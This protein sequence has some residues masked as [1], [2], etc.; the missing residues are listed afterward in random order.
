[1]RPLLGVQLQRSQTLWPSLMMLCIRLSIDPVI[2]IFK[3]PPRPS[4]QSSIAVGQDKMTR[5]GCC[6]T[7]SIVPVSF[8]I[9]CL[10]W[11]TTR[12]RLTNTF[13]VCYLNNAC[14]QV[15]TVFPVPTVQDDLLSLAFP[16]VST[17]SL[18]QSSIPA[19]ETTRCCLIK[20]IVP[21]YISLR[22]R[23]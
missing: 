3:F 11:E 8:M 13:I 14:F 9:P 10:M 15:S 17:A 20:L 18:L 16:Q 7:S 2:H 4:L 22:E 23:A 12:C 5:L 21:S 19:H 1:M 6:L